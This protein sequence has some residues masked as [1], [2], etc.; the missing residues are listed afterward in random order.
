MEAGVVISYSCA[1]AAFRPFAIVLPS[2]YLGVEE[3]ARDIRGKS[4]GDVSWVE[5]RCG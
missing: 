3:C 2:C 4:Y 5:G 1:G